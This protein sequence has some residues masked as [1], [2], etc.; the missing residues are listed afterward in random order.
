MS[1]LYLITARGGSKGIPGKNIK[2]LINKPLLYY[3]IDVARK[4]VSD[5]FIC[6]SSDDDAIIKSAESYGLKVPF[7]R[8]DVLAQDKSGSYEVILHALE[9]YLNKGYKIDKIVLL[10]PTS[11]FRL[12]SDVKN[13]LQLFTE[14]I[15]AVYSVKITHAN[16]FQ[17]LYVQN[18]SGYLEK[19]I[20]SKNYINRQEMPIV[21][22]LNG[23]I[24]VFNSSSIL[25]TKISEFKKCIPSVMN[26]INSIDIDTPLDW[27]WA[28]F[29]LKNNKIHF[30][31]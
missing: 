17:L 12:V 25:N 5:E 28:E 1:T 9:F 27:E 14:S 31:Y 21:Y 10:Q 24:Y 19:V 6:L 30:D 26:D 8:P 3:A 2:L 15:D 29:L 7:I 13:A 22:E 23:A 11:P 18:N 4:F 20:S 16:P